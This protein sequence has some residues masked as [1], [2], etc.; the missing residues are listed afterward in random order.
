M[1]R[2][3]R[4]GSIPSSASGEAGPL[5]AIRAARSSDSHSS[6]SVIHGGM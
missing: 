3:A 6:R 1:S 5:S 2:P 4:E